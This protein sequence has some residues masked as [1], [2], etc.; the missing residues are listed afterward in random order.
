M[1]FAGYFR[2]ATLVQYVPLPVVRMPLDDALCIRQSS[3]PQACIPGN[4]QQPNLMQLAEKQEHIHTFT[5]WLGMV[6]PCA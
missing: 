2:L 3:S 6:S 5:Y 4:C 1:A